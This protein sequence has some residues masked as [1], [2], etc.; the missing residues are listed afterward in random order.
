[1]GLPYVFVYDTGCTDFD[2]KDFYNRVLAKSEFK[3]DDLKDIITTQQVDV[4]VLNFVERVRITI[5]G[6]FV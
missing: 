5:Q 3:I 2:E 1:M 4:L 6:Q